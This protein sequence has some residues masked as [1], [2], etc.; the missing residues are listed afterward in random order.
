M[1]LYNVRN[2]F[3]NFFQ[4]GVPEP[5]GGYGW[6]SVMDASIIWP[7]SAAVLYQLARAR[8]RVRAH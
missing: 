2:S 1:F 3:I 4:I 7:A 6:L 8:P 5:T